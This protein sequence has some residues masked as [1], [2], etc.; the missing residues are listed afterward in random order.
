MH[1][2]LELKVLLSLVTHFQGCLQGIPGQGHT[3][4]KAKLIRPRLAEL[5][6]QQGVRQSKVQLDGNVPGVLG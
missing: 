1:Q 2:N 4:H 3:V 6:A 5:L